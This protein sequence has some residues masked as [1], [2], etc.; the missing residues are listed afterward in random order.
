MAS[1]TITE[2]IIDDAFI[3]SFFANEI[4]GIQADDLLL[5]PPPPRVSALDQAATRAILTEYIYSCKDCH[6]SPASYGV[7]G[8]KPFAR[9]CSGCAAAH[10]G[11][12]ASLSK[13]RLCVDCQEVSSTYGI[14]GETPFARWCSGCAIEDLL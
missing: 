7:I 2:D 3:M 12:G 10:E 9:W 13:S 1:S 6:V 11:E 8:D 5:G 4:A 14:T